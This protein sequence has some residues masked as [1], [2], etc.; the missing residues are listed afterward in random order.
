MKLVLVFFKKT[1]I[2][3]IYVLLGPES[4]PNITNPAP[5]AESRLVGDGPVEY[6]CDASGSPAPTI[7][8]Y[9][10]AAV[11]QSGSGG[12]VVGGDGTLTISAPQ[13][14]HSGIYQ[15]FAVNRFGEDSRAWVLE[16]LD[17]GMNNYNVLCTSMHPSRNSGHVPS[18]TT[19]LGG[20]ACRGRKRTSG[21]SCQHSRCCGKSRAPQSLHHVSR[22]CKV[23][24]AINSVDN[25]PQKPLP[26]G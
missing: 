2:C 18:L 8:W 4:S 19:F 1:V 9:Y 13:V 23:V 6:R 25:I 10:N 3:N 7:T 22:A 11:I 5:D 12:V 16:V 24:A 17:P 21:N 20:G 26:E 14:S 15:C